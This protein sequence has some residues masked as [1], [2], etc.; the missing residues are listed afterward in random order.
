MQQKLVQSLGWEDP[1]EKEMV[2]LPGESHKQRSRA[3]Y[4]PW[5]RKRDKYDL[6]TKQQHQR[7]VQFSGIKCTDTALQ[8]LP[9]S[10]SRTFSSSQTETLYLFKKYRSPFSSP[11][12]PG[13][14]HPPLV[15]INVTILGT[16]PSAIKAVF[17]LCAW[18]IS[19]AQCLQDS[20]MS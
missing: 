20:S 8:P 17:A 1:L 19:H 7:S 6:V 14:Y 2:S 13:I 12:V 11:S 5:G 10:I 4:S 15:S 16:S 9:P 18:L 3:G